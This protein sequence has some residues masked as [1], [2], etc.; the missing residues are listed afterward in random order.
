MLTRAG[1]TPNLSIAH[2]TLT[3]GV[4]V[5][6]KHCHEASLITTAGTT[7]IHAGCHVRPL[8]HLDEHGQLVST[9]ADALDYCYDIVRKISR[10][11][12][13]ET[14]GALKSEQKQ[15]P[16]DSFFV[17]VIR[18]DKTLYGALIFK[19]DGLHK[20]YQ[21]VC[22]IVNTGRNRVMGAV[23]DWAKYTLAEYEH[24]SSWVWFLKKEV[25]ELR[26]EYPIAIVAFDDNGDNAIF[27]LDL[28]TEKEVLDLHKE[29]K[30]NGRLPYFAVCIP[31]G[32][33][34]ASCRD[35]QVPLLS[36]DYGVAISA[37]RVKK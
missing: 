10:E 9:G 29:L 6:D 5:F 34:E 4:K 11:L 16:K 27:G 3:T 21:L 32:D 26:P 7:N 8:Q 13:M 36:G 25:M 18:T 1:V 28:N 19:S 15:H 30:Q 12:S 14:L 37:F 22:Y 20:P 23:Y 17:S 31:K 35:H 24:L 33:C 2:L